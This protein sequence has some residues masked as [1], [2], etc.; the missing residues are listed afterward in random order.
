LITVD[1]AA[2]P[3][4][5]DVDRVVPACVIHNR[6]YYQTKPSKIMSRGGPTRAADPQ[7]TSIDVNQ[8]LTGFA[9]HGTINEYTNDWA[10]QAIKA[11]LGVVD[12]PADA[13]AGS[14]LA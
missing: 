12:T 10:F 7:A 6:N 13:P 14:A 2:G 8:D 1:I 3:V 5:R 4:S 9:E 11:Q